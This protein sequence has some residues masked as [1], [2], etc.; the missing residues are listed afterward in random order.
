MPYSHPL[1]PL[2]PVQPGIPLNR[3]EVPPQPDTPLG[4]T[5]EPRQPDHY[6]NETEAPLEPG[7][8]LHELQSSSQLDVPHDELVAQPGD[9]SLAAP[10]LASIGTLQGWPTQPH[11]VKRSAAS[12]IMDIVLDAT[13][14]CASLAFVV[15]ALTVWSHDQAE[16]ADYP[17][18]T[19][20]LINATKYVSRHHGH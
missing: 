11:R 3:I 8:D 15:F 2:G 1:S 7:T 17:H 13:L 12:L 18:L 20:N 19:I 14:I 6:R 5:E 4:M 16:T 9:T 10:L